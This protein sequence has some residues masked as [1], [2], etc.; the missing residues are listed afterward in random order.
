MLY[1]GS[2]GKIE[3]V[4]GTS[5]QEEDNQHVEWLVENGKNEE[6]IMTLEVMETNGRDAMEAEEERS[7]GKEIDFNPKP[8]PA[9][10]VRC[11]DQ[12]LTVS[13]VQQSGDAATIMAVHSRFAV[14][15]T[16]KGRVLITDHQG[17]ALHTYDDAHSGAVTDASFDPSGTIVSTCSR[18]GTVVV[19]SLFGQPSITHTFSQPLRAV[20][21]DPICRENYRFVTGGKDKTLH[22]VEPQT[23]ISKLFSSKR[24]KEKIVK[25]DGVIHSVKWRGELIAWGT[26]NGIHLYDSLKHKP[27]QIPDLELPRKEA[28]FRCSICW[29]QDDTL[30]IGWGG[31]LVT[32][33]VILKPTAE[34]RSGRFDVELLQRF[35]M[36]DG[37]ICSVAP[38]RE[39]II[40]LT[41]P[42]KHSCGDVTPPAMQS[43]VQ[44][45][46][47]V[48]SREVRDLKEEMVYRLQLT[49][50]EN[51]FAMHFRLYVEEYSDDVELAYF[52]LTPIEIVA[53][54][55]RDA[56]GH[57]LFLAGSGRSKEAIHS[58]KV[59]EAS[60]R[61]AIQKEEA[62]MR[63]AKLTPI[64]AS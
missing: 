51:L 2:F 40:A 16:Q 4:L 7:R 10:G 11:W 38:F 28:E 32:L 58:I 24:D 26:E 42:C 41:I 27:L 35:S 48:L 52:I 15:G 62:D 34:Q 43:R 45:E 12:R 30:L 54:S 17:S 53:I 25:T 13:G 47:R 33:C 20:S 60:S 57:I 31:V 1:G 39:K 46:L 14:I 49:G 36:P 29:E 63:K 6:A 50:V 21:L 3:D 44:P 8:H 23:G 59:L 9:K 64:L 61:Q 37:L 22:I 18:D 5:N 56:V 55:P 19:F